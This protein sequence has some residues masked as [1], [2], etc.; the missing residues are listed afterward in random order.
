VPNVEWRLPWKSRVFVLAVD[1]VDTDQIIPAR[2]LKSTGQDGF[3]ERLFADWRTGDRPG[4]SFDSRA[5]AG[6]RILL[7]GANFGSG[8]SREH[9]AWA[10]RDFGFAVIVARSFSDIFRANALEN[11]I[12]PAAIEDEPWGRLR[13]AATAGS[14]L[15]VDLG[16]QL[17][18]ADSARARFPIDPFSRHCLLQSVDQLGY[19]VSHRAAIEEFERARLTAMPRET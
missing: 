11:G 18:S 13:A 7:A 19:L 8:S 10:L 16:N 9:A 6:A 4:R 1:D 15:T 5:A 3:G 14:E 12:L 2:F 17:V